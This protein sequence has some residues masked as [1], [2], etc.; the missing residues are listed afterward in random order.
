MAC[1]R[2]GVLKDGKLLYQGTVSGLLEL[3]N[4]KVYEVEV[5]EE[6]LKGKLE[7]WGDRVLTT[8]RVDSG[9][10]VRLLGEVEG[11]RP[12]NPSLEDAYLALIR[13]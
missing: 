5:P 1:E 4:G 7:A 13:S 8:K 6:G 11:A 12:V 10:A 9:R 2:L 3:Y